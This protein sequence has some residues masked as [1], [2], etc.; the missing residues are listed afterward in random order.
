MTLLAE[1]H[2]LYEPLREEFSADEYRPFPPYGM[3]FKPIPFVFR[4]DL[5]GNCLNVI[6]TRSKEFKAGAPRVQAEDPKR[7]SGVKALFITDKLTYVAGFATE[8]GKE[9]SEKRA[10]ESY[11]QYVALLQ[12]F[13]DGSQE[14][15]AKELVQSVLLFVEEKENVAQVLKENYP[16]LYD[17]STNPAKKQKEL[18]NFFCA[19]N[20]DGVDLF[21]ASAPA[22]IG[23]FWAKKRRENESGDVG[24]CQVLGEE[25]PL[26]RLFPSIPI[27]GTSAPLVSA[28]EDSLLRY[29]AVQASG[30]RVSAE[31]AGKS[32]HTLGWLLRNPKNTV[33]IDDATFVWW[34]K[35]HV[36]VETFGINALP[37]P[38]AA[39]VKEMLNSSM[40]GG[41]KSKVKAT[42][43]FHGVMLE[44]RGTGRVI[45]RS[46]DVSTIGEVEQR[47]REWFEKTKVVNKNGVRYYGIYALAGAASPPKSGGRKDLASQKKLMNDLLQHA[48]F[49]KPLPLSHLGPTLRR[50]RVEGM[51]DARAVLISLLIEKP[52]GKET[53]ERTPAFICGELL[54]E[55]DRLQYHA[56]G[57]VNRTV[58]EKFFA[59]ASVSPGRTFPGV[60]KK[61]SAHLAKVKREKPGLAVNI[62]KRL[63][64]LQH[65]IA[66]LSVF[67]EHL[68]LRGQAEF[69]LG[70]WSNRH[71]RFTKEKS[72]QELEESTTNGGTNND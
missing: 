38:D 33:R 22:S 26:A 66:E 21:D 16:D 45:L 24:V 25:L 65:E 60:M 72:E 27:G 3:V 20:V 54:D 34:A 59:S 58:G 41:A 71:M 18:A 53:M 14:E 35:E 68:D 31:V 44:P 51:S 15:R 69:S 1:L 61:A 57:N 47:L 39:R 32:Q 37:E 48:L 70:F 52:I 2:S 55:F 7:T 11:A 12:E 6:D 30:A 28:N 49:G 8:P 17:F 42:D 10:A 46:S 9:K 56:L 67:P 4:L 40:W 5:N 13:I 63:A 64:A 36:G 23:D 62:S 19:F 50:A 43:K 29:N